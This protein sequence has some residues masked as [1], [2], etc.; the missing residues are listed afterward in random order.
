MVREGLS[1]EVASELSPGVEKEPAV[2]SVEK[3]VFR[4]EGGQHVQRP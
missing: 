4:V 1:E 3:S 2:E